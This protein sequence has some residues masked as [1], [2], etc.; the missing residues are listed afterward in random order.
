MKVLVASFKCFL[1]SDL[2]SYQ[3]KAIKKPITN[4]QSKIVIKECSGK[5][6]PIYFRQKYSITYAAYDV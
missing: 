5:C 2:L 1:V 3:R 4:T 6:F